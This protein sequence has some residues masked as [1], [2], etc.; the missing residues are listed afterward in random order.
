MSHCIASVHGFEL[1]P[2]WLRERAANRSRRPC[3]T[4]RKIRI[5]ICGWDGIIKDSQI[6]NDSSSCFWHKVPLG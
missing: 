2:I 1:R 3:G 4:E 5:W 6:L